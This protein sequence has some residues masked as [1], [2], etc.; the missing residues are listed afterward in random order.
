MKY[1]VNEE[2]VTAMRTMSNRLRDALEAVDQITQTL[3][4]EA[5]AGQNVLGPHKPSLDDA[6]DCID[7]SVRQA[8]TTDSAAAVSAR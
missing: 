3:R 7:Q 6:L 8:A 5:D 4:S 2:G 1:A